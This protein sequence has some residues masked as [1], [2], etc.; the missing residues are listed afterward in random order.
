MD[1]SLKKNTKIPFF[2]ELIDLD[3]P[4]TLNTQF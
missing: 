4:G 2:N 1:A 3:L